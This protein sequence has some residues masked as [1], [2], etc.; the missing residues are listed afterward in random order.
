MPNKNDKTIFNLRKQ[1]AQK[2]EALAA[3]EKFVPVTN[4]S[5]ELHGTRYN[6]HALGKES[7]A[8]LLVELNALRL[9]AKDLGISESE[10]PMCGFTISDWIT[11]VKSKLMNV[12]RKTEEDRLNEMERKLEGLLSEA[13]RTELEIQNIA[14]SL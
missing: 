14:Q 7:L 5:I 1:I 12:N 9:S 8:R 11:D 6:I 3:T 10:W 13:T 4:C 2:K